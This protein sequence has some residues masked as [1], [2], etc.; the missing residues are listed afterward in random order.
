MYTCLYYVVDNN[1]FEFAINNVCQFY[2]A[3]LTDRYLY[4]HIH[5]LQAL[6]LLNSF[7]ENSHLFS[8]LRNIQ[9]NTFQNNLCYNSSRLGYHCRKFTASPLRNNGWN[10]RTYISNLAT[11]HMCCTPLKYSVF[12]FQSVALILLPSTSLLIRYT[13]ITRTA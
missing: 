5:A 2:V 11:C 4:N 12:Y 9:L 3:S 8:V 10:C 1:N 13:E 6:L 7:T